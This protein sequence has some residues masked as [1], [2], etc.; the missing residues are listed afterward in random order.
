MRKHVK[1]VPML[2]AAL[3]VTAAVI[4]AAYANTLT[5]LIP[6]LYAGMDVVS[7]ELVGFVPSVYRNAAAERA[8][9]NEAVR[10]QV[11]PLPV[12]VDV[13]PAMAIPEP[14]DQTIGSGTVTISKS[15]AVPFGFVG[16]EQKGLN[17]GAGYLSVQA[18][19]FAQALRVLVNEMEA[20]LALAAKL[21][22]S[23]AT[24]TAGTTPFASTLGDSAQLRKILDDNGAPL[25]ERSIV[26]GTAMGANL[27][28]LTQLTKVNEAGQS[29]TLRDGELI[30]LHGFSIKESGQVVTHTKGTNNGSA[31]T[32]NAGYAIGAT[33]ITLASAGTGTIV[34]GDVIT[35]AGDSNKYVVLTG[36]ADV[37]NGGTIV[38]QEPGLR[39][40][41]PASNTVITTG[42]NYA[43][44]IGFTRSAIHLVARAPALPQEGDLALD[45]MMIT[46]PRSGISFEVSVYGGYRKVRFEVALAWGYKVV[47]PRHVGIL[48][49]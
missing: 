47:A 20:D 39:Q 42:A 48:L 12:A 30:N 31:S 38:L 18:D 45:R 44:N 22:G 10:Y 40:A 2:A 49:G 23:R 8:A 17:N 25:S 43:A 6:D 33:T 5:N 21:G 4:P 34:A 41:I 7:R 15:R 19:M 37:S 27:R 24:G 36:D 28:T 14:A 11:A 3:L 13:T 16:E 32:N 46:D 9:V 35:F 29:M 1:A 26:G